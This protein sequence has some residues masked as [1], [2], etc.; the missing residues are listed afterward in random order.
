M[1]DATN[2]DEF[3]AL[4]DASALAEAEL[5]KAENARDETREAASAA[6]KRA[7]SARSALDAW[8]TASVQKRAKQEV[9]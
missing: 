4:R 1:T 9:T 6:S 2:F 8:V 7:V 3:L 5:M